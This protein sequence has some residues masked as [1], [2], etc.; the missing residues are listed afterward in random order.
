LILTVAVQ[1]S[2]CRMKG[3][4]ITIVELQSMRVMKKTHYLSVQDNLI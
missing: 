1:G 2:R 3:I 4:I